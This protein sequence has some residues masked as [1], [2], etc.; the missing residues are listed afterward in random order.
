LIEIRAV[1]VGA[2]Q[3]TGAKK[4]FLKKVQSF[5]DTLYNSYRNNQQDTTVYQN[6]LFHVYM[7][8]NSFGRYAAHHQ[9]LKIALAASGFSIRESLLDVEVA[10][11]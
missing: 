7:K 3:T 10:G 4:K 8:L 2:H 11:L 1:S 9:A 5:S 6:L